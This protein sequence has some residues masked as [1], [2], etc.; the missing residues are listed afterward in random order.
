MGIRQQVSVTLR[1]PNNLTTRISAEVF[2]KE[3]ESNRH[4]VRM[5]IN[6]KGEISNG[7][8]TQKYQNRVPWREEYSRFRTRTVRSWWSYYGR[9]SIPGRYRRG[10]N[11]CST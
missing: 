11:A 8:H 9:H 4:S 5:P 7:L 2:T 10:W 3:S 1:S 6:Y